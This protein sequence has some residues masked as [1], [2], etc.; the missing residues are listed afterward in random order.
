ME[1]AHSG[2]DINQSIEVDAFHRRDFVH[3]I[4]PC[5]IDWDL[6]DVSENPSNGEW[7]TNA[8]QAESHE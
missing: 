1:D 8:L 4:R 5:S 3:P 7:D 6:A 2:G